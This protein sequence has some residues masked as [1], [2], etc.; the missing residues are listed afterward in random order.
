MVLGRAAVPKSLEHTTSTPAEDIQ[1]VWPEVVKKY[2]KTWSKKVPKQVQN[3]T[4][5][6]AWEGQ[7]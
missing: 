5:K 6:G 4:Q 1:K 7:K 3:A 2:T